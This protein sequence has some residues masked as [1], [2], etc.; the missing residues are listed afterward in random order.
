LRYLRLFITGLIFI[1]LLYKFI[2]FYYIVTGK[3]TREYINREMI[4]NSVISLS[5]VINDDGWLVFPFEFRGNL[6]RIVSNANLPMNI[7]L[8]RDEDWWYSIR[9]QV[10]G[11]DGDVL[12]DRTHALHSK[13]TFYR[14]K[15]WGE[16]T[17]SFYTEPN[18]IPADSRE[19][20]VNISRLK[21]PHA[22]RFKLL[23]KDKDIKDISVRVYIRYEPRKEMPGYMWRRFSK[24]KKERLAMG[25]VYPPQLLTDFEKKQLLKR[26]WRPLGP[27][28]AEGKDFISRKLYV[29]KEVEAEEVD[30]YIP[31]IGLFI[32]E[33]HHVTVAVPEGGGR[34][35]LEFYNNS[36]EQP[37]AL[38]LSWYG[39]EIDQ[40]IEKTIPWKER[41]RTSIESFFDTGLIDLYSEEPVG[42]KVFLINK[43]G[44]IEITPDPLYVRA[45][46]SSLNKPVTFRISH[47]EKDPT[48]FKVTL[49]LLLRRGY[50]PDTTADYRIYGNDGRVIY[51]GRLPLNP[52][53][54][55]YDTISGHEPE[56][57]VSEPME[58]FFYLPYEAK[59][60]SFSSDTE[61]LVLGYTR[62][63]DMIRSINVPEDYLPSTPLEDKEP[64]WYA[65]R[66]EEY[67]SLIYEARSVIIIINRRP[68]ERR[69]ELITGR[70]GWEDYTPEGRYQ[71]SYV[72]TDEI[73]G[74]RPERQSPNYY[75]PLKSGI[76]H[77]IDV[78]EIAGLDKTPLRLIYLLNKGNGVM[79]RVYIDD[80]PVLSKRLYAMVGEIRLTSV[81]SGNHRIRIE[82]SDA[83]R[84]YI[85]NIHYKE[86]P[87]LFKRFTSRVEREGL[88]FIYAK[89]TPFEDIL[90]ARFYASS[91]N[92]HRSIIDVDIQ[93]RRV[94]G[95]RPFNSWT[96]LRRQFSIRPDYTARLPLLYG[97]EGYLQPGQLLFIKIGDDLPQGQYRIVFKPASGTGYISL[98][99][100]TPGEY[101][102]FRFYNERASSYEDIY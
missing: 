42:M 95:F 15:R 72:L 97:R 25:N 36:E 49:R 79:L 78:S 90:S 59:R 5:Y 39:R 75:I 22:I 57:E 29:L 53:P 100:I 51:S 80:L 24:R 82:S 84:F 47:H 12:I 101:E 21:E 76:D 32:E 37:H 55:L 68:P 70:Y 7:N 64:S 89:D 62:P 35:R 98:H 41:E 77:I 99:R 6:L 18:I 17:S 96:F 61:M 16:F 34:L 3:K 71:A 52:T 85:N 44:E 28:G 91:E 48:P 50:K 86:G 73:K 20:R 30:I 40:Y 87:I 66:P 31:P 63:D 14:D 26:Q 10:I 94:A 27:L 74:M 46:I 43:T 83:G 19:F 1:Y 13:V 56:I 69:E 65:I 45:Y 54:S 38:R 33:G 58:Y 81:K 2:P 11:D 9:Y 23:R 102:E 67:W 8:K 93:A 60:I 4:E 88:S 92:S